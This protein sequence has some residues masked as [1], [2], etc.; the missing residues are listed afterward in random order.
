MQA[1]QTKAALLAVF[2][3][4][5]LRSEKSKAPTSTGMRGGELSKSPTKQEGRAINFHRERRDLRHH[6]CRE[7]GHMIAACPMQNRGPKC[8]KYQDYGHISSKCNKKRDKHSYATVRSSNSKCTKKV[9]MCG[10]EVV[11]LVDTGSDL[12]LMRATQ[13]VNIDAPPLQ[14]HVGQFRGIGSDLNQTLEEFTV[15]MIIND[16]MYLVKIHVIPDHLI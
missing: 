6:N 13:Y 16:I 9:S 1:S 4:L 14:K 3:R 5:N 11:A 12:C 7:K 15:D 10:K 8:F 2:E